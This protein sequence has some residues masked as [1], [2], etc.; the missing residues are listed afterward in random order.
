MRNQINTR[1]SQEV[2][3]FGTRQV[4]MRYMEPK[5]AIRKTLETFVVVKSEVS[6]VDDR[7]SLG[8]G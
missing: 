1:Q 8:L 6:R 5:L 4:R 7:V 2:V 3:F